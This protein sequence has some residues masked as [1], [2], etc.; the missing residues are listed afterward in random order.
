VPSSDPNED[1]KR[2]LDGSLEISARDAI[3]V[4]V[5]H[6]QQVVRIMSFDIAFDCIP[7]IERIG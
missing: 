1:A 7:G 2:V 3:H 5:M 4:A 6:R